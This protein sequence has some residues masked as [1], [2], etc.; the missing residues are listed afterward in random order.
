MSVTLDYFVKKLEGR[1]PESL[2]DRTVQ[3]L[4]AQPENFWEE[5]KFLNRLTGELTQ[6][7]GDQELS[8]AYT[9]L[10]STRDEIMD[11]YWQAI[12]DYIIHH[13]NKHYFDSWQGFSNIR[14]NKYSSNKK[15]AEHVDH[16]SHIFDGERAGIPIL[17]VLGCLNDT[18]TGGEFMM[19]EDCHIKFNKGDVL[20]FPS[21]F[22]FPHR[23][24]P[25]KSGTKYSIVSWVW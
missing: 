11:V 9:D 18:Y 4:D 7:S 20:V 22:M 15:M 16:V 19:F 17:T 13:I 14:F 10:I 24:E 8:T 2:C 3:E 5:H 12:H 6:P 21:N 23:V 25:V 1:L